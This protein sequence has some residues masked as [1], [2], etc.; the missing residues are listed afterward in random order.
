MKWN[1]FSTASKISAKMGLIIT[2]NLWRLLCKKEYLNV[3]FWKTRRDYLI[4]MLELLFVKTRLV[5]SIGIFTWLHKKWPR[6]LAHLPNT[7]FCTITLILKKKISSKWPS[8]NVPITT[9]GKE[10]LKFPQLWNT[11]ICWPISL[12]PLWILNNLCQ[13]NWTINY[14]ISELILNY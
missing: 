6:V 2:H 11:Q 4:L 1:K 14:I 13:K 12:P 8:V 9:I 10:P 3:S 7:L 5:K